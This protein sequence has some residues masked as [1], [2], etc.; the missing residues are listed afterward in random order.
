VTGVGRLDVTCRAV[1][2]HLAPNSMAPMSDDLDTSRSARRLLLS[3]S[4]FVLG[5]LGIFSTFGLSWA[6]LLLTFVLVLAVSVVRHMGWMNNRSDED[7]TIEPGSVECPHCSA[8]QT[9]Y[10]TRYDSSGREYEQLHC[11]ACDRD[12]DASQVETSS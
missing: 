5:T 10:E 3:L 9:D 2:L 8:M 11:F 12:I 6:A 1:S 4:A 7:D